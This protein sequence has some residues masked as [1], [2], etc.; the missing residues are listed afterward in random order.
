MEC[1]G[2]AQVISQKNRTSLKLFTCFKTTVVTSVSV[3]NGEE[4]ILKLWIWFKT[5]EFALIAH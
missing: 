2:R 5:N 4:I 1:T 3:E